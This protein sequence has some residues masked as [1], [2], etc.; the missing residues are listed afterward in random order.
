MPTFTHPPLAAPPARPHA[1][2]GSVPLARTR[3]VGDVEAPPGEGTTSRTRAAVAEA[4]RVHYAL[5]HRLA[6]RYGRGRAAFADDVTQEVFVQLL[7]H[8]EALDDL[9]ALEGWLYRVTTRRCLT[10]LR[11]ERI[12]HALTFRWL[13]PD[14]EPTVDAQALV[15]ARDELR[16]AFQALSALP[17]KE[18]VAFSMFHLDGR[19]MDEI[20]GMLGCSKGY[21]SKLVQRATQALRAQGWEVAP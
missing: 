16:R 18:R 10:K 13:V 1:S 11:N 9:G 14:S 8:A 15:G 12:V 5:V 3:A 21:V 7:R 6:L 2:P 20:G 4:Y 17:D 19:S